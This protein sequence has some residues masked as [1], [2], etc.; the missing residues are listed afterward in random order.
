VPPGPY[1]VTLDAKA[2]NGAE[3]LCLQ[4]LFDVTPPMA[5]TAAAALEHKAAKM[6]RG[7]QLRA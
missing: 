1:N 2:A 6:F 3:L 7:Q 4:V 5:V